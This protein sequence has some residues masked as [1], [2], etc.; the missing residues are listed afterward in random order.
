MK[1][2]HF[3]YFSKTLKKF[4]LSPIVKQS[5]VK[6]LK[7]IYGM[8]FMYIFH[9]FCQ[10]FFHFFSVSLQLIAFW[11]KTF[12]FIEGLIIL[13]CMSQGKTSENL[14]KPTQIIFAKNNKNFCLRFEN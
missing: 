9:L 13:Y 6:I 3:Y 7:K 10:I 8:I 14:S 4:I 2:F 1:S 11:R 12:S 5:M